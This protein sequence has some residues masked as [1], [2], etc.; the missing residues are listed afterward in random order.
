MSPAEQELSDRCYELAKN[1]GGILILVQPNGPPVVA[2]A[3]DGIPIPWSRMAGMLADI[4][5]SVMDLA[6]TLVEAGA[7]PDF[8]TLV[9]VEAF[10]YYTARKMS[11]VEPEGEI[12]IQHHGKMDWHGTGGDAGGDT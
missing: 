5:A 8:R 7:G 11:G 1:V 4:V 3:S 12:R 9:G 2:G 10:R 6:D